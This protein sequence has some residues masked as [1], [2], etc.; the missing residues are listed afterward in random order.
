MV[1]LLLAWTAIT[2]MRILLLMHMTD[3]EQQNLRGAKLVWQ[4]LAIVQCQ[5]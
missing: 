3:D 2:A 4:S 1:L 5:K